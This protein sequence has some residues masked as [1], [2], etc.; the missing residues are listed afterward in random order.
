MAFNMEKRIGNVEELHSFAEEILSI[1]PQSDKGQVI[2]LRGNLGAG[3][4]AFT[5]ALAKTLG[6]S[7]HVVSPTFVIMRIYE[8][9]D[10]R[11][12]K[13]VHIDAY[14][15]EDEEEVKVLRLEDFLHESG[16]IVCIEWPERIPSYVRDDALTIT[17]AM[18]EDES[19][20][21]TYGDKK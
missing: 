17:F 3:K 6:V 1:M 14:R 21:V 13:L 20:T 7:E 12:K 16:I 8:T 9:N 5:Q 4:T 19:R 2:A 15:I 10:E 18:N 11:F